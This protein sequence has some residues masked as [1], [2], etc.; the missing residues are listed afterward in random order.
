[1]LSRP[2]LCALA[3][4]PLVACQLGRAPSEPGPT[5]GSSPGDPSGPLLPPR[6]PDIV[7]RLSGRVLAPEGTIPIAGALIYVTS[8]RP[9]PIPD[10][11]YCDRCVRLPEG[12]PH[13]RSGADGRFTLP[14]PW[15][16]P[17]HLVVQKGAFRRVRPIEVRP[18]DQD[19]AAELTTLPGRMDKESGDDIP[20]MA[21]VVGAWDKIEVSLAKLGLGKLSWFGVDKAS[22]AFDLF[23]H[24]LFPNPRDPRSPERLLRDPE[25]LMK[26]HVVFLPCSGSEGTTCT[27]RTSADPVVQRNLQQFV[28]RGGKLYVTDYTYDFV[29]QIFPGYMDWIGQTQQIG[30]ACMERSYDAPADVQD[31]GLRDWLAAQGIVDFQVRENWT[32]VE[33]VNTVDALDLDGQPVRVTPKVWVEALVPQ[34]GR[35]PATV[36]FVRGCGRVLFSTYHTEGR[37]DRMGLLP[38]ERALLYVLLETAVCVEPRVL[39]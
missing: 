5:E 14:L 38:Q 39:E 31:A 21:V 29:R 30:S 8:R 2:L 10:G 24:G 32:A 27:D 25:T 28:A 3:L 4:L 22:L 6:E 19:L 7:A 1:M 33:R 23:E 13:V 18:G 20:R 12:T 16:G 26:Y 15:V 9:P 11:V 17:L 34:H 37:G 36:S 35:R